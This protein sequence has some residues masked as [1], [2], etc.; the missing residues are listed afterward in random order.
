MQT[1]KNIFVGFA[2]T[3]S[4][5]KQIEGKKIGTKHIKIGEKHKNSKIFR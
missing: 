1:Y 4:T 3:E 2:L 5:Q